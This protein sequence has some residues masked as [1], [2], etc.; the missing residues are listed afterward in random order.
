MSDVENR[1]TRVLAQVLTDV[2][3]AGMTPEAD[4]IDE[5]GMDSLQMISF[6]LAV[7]DEFGIE[8]DYENLDLADL[9]SV[10]QFAAY[11]AGLRVETQA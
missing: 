8:L 11:L 4:L 9:R 5:Y 1:I 6:L 10:R 2:A 3:A 7:E